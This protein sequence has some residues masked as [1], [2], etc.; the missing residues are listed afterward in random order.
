MAKSK[1]LKDDESQIVIDQVLR[2]KELVK[3][4]KKLI[5]AIGKL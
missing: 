5:D 3:E 1:N 2:F 4:H